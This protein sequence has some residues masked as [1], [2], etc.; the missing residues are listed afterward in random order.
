MPEFGH[1]DFVEPVAVPGQ[2]PQ[3]SIREEILPDRITRH[4]WT[5]SLNAL[6]TLEERR[7]E[8]EQFRGLRSQIYQFRDQAP[9]KTILISSGMPGEGKSFVAVN[10]AISL[11]RNRNDSVLLIDADLRKPMLHKVLGAPNTPGL[12]EYLA[13]TARA[14]EVLQ[15]NQNTHIRT[16]SQ[17]RHIP[18]LTFIASGDSGDHSSELVANHRT[19]ELV[20]TLSPHFDWI[21]IDSPPILAVADAIELARAADAVALVARAAFTPFNVAQRAQSAFANSRLL[22]FVLNA[23]KHAPESGAYYYYG[24]PDGKSG[25]Y[26]RKG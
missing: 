13:G 6:P 4:S 1:P 7:E 19:E 8:T 11:A 15:R 22:G 14:S 5:P 21:I 17:S 2:A 12:G 20:E 25:S 16:D 18:D 9:L 23:V 24:K 10:L 3:P 26:G